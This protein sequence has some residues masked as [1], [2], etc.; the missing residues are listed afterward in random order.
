MCNMDHLVLA[1]VVLPERYKVGRVHPRGVH[2]DP[3]M[4]VCILACTLALRHPMRIRCLARAL[5]PPR[6]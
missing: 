5:P 2:V 3:R 4:M 6:I 1:Y